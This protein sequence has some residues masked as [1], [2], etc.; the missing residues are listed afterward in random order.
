[1]DQKDK[2]LIGLIDNFVTRKALGFGLGWFIDLYEASRDGVID[3]PEFILLVSSSDFTGFISTLARVVGFEL[4]PDAIIP[5]SERLAMVDSLLKVSDQSSFIINMMPY[6]GH[7]RKASSD[8]KAANV[9]MCPQCEGAMSA[10][11]YVCAAVDCPHCGV[12][13]KIPND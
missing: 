12:L 1:M 7:F 8:E 4:K 11:K 3:T 6:I 10:M 5:D 13:S 2:A 9:I